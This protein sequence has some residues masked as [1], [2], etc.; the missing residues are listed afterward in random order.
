MC[1]YKSIVPQLPY[2]KIS[3]VRELQMTHFTQFAHGQSHISNLVFLPICVEVS[4]EGSTWLDQ[5]LYCYG[6]LIHHS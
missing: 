6:S 1:V 2:H 3:V 5:Y 4:G